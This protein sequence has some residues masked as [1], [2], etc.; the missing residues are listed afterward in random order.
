MSDKEKTAFPT[1]VTTGG[2]LK[3]KSYVEAW[4]ESWDKASLE[5]KKKVL[6]LPNWDNDIFK[7]ISGID[8]LQEIGVNN[9]KSELLRKVEQLETKAKETREEINKF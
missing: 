2:Y 4:R 7:E 9:K 3:E 5:D 8:V 6:S 1:Y